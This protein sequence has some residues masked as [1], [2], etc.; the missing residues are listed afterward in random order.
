VDCHESFDERVLRPCWQAFATG[1]TPNPCILCNARVRFEK[2]VEFADELGAESAA[3]GH[4][5]RTEALTDGTVR[6]LRGV[7]PKKDQSYFLHAVPAALLA[8]I[9]FPLGGLL[10]TEIR[11]M[12]R[13]HGLVNSERAE[14]QDVCFAGPDGHFAEYLR[15]QFHGTG[16]PGVIRDTG[17]RVLGT[18]EGVHR[19]TLG[20]RRGLGVAAGVPVRVCAIDAV[21]GTIVVSAEPEDLLSTTCDVADCRWIAAPPSVGAVFDAQ[22]RYQQTP[23]RATVE[24]AGEADGRIR[25]RFATPVA[26]VTPGQWLVLYD[27]DAVVGGGVIDCGHADG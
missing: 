23:V 17:G 12:A 14:S 1:R 11:A 3:T 19:F 26:A 4:Y 24:A 10:K 25:V 16:V 13:A 15:T 6:L 9:L 5:A 18:H 22:I 7:D 8:R 2:L 21:S 27:G 20:Q